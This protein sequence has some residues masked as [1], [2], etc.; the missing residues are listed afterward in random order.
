MERV[1]THGAHVFLV[2]E[3]AFK[4]KR[5]VRFSFLDF[6]TLER[7]ET[8]LRAEL[9]LNRRTAPMLY[10]RVLPVTRDAAGALALDGDGEPVEWLLEMRRFPAEAE[11]DRV[12]GRGG[13]DLDLAASLGET[14][15]R[16]HETAEACPDAGGYAAMR[17]II[18]GNTGDLARLVPHLLDEDELQALDY[19]TL[20]ELERR[21][22]LLNGRCAAGRVRLCHGDLHLG[23]IVLLDGR[24]VLFDCIEFSEA[25]ATC[26]VLYDLAFLLMDLVDRGL[27]PQ[28]QRVLQA[29]DDLM[30][31]DE[32][33]ALLP[34]FISVRAVIRAKVSGLNAEVLEDAA[35]RTEKIAEAR[36]Y[37]ALARRA[38]EP[39]PARLVA[40]GGRSGT[41]KSTL[42]QAL[43]PVIGA[44][45]GA[46]V[47]RSDVIRKRLFGVAPTERLPESAYT[48][49]VSA[50]VFETIARRAATLLA[51]GRAVVADGVY[52]KAEHRAA[53]GAVAREAG[54]RF[55]G[56][57]LMAPE[58]VLLERVTARRGDASDA[59][60]RIVLAQRRM[61]EASVA[62][63]Q[64][65]ADRPLAD[66]VAETLTVLES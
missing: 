17:E 26:D 35:A 51:A 40:V 58:A 42:A 54:A 38:L 66:L 50:R 37:L 3:R 43:A 33:L 44:M 15:A 46:V 34:L 18:E 57:W 55:D 6:S 64:L 2:G 9:E 47:L 41:G 19:A 27:G 32:G 13:L 1:D 49:E 45:P 62:W 31:E 14:I 25:L 56:I 8:V 60:R 61:D 16:F 48:A 53:I 29:Y 63:R 10:R 21:K 52:G 23:N 65:R 5:A 39:A 24:P 30:V 12:A 59:D 20:A 7:R 22:A 28:A 4:M 36:G 11:L